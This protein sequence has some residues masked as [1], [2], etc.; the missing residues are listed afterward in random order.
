MERLCPALEPLIGATIEYSNGL[1]FPTTASYTCDTTAGPPPD[2]DATRACQVD[3]TWAGESPT[4][5]PPGNLVL[6]GP[7]RCRDGNSDLNGCDVYNT[8]TPI[9]ADGCRQACLDWE[10][11]VGA[12]VPT[13]GPGRCIL[14]NTNI[15][16]S[17]AGEC[18][19]T[20][21]CGEST[22]RI[23]PTIE[24]TTVDRCWRLT[25]EVDGNVIARADPE[26]TGVECWV[27]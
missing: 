17:G 27:K 11:C 2:G 15:A 22:R 14:W 24:G 23:R 10:F 26:Y 12:D 13:P 3:G 9:T 6:L 5:C 20:V 16:D 4:T 1:V 8:A 7:G 21:D 19:E 18:V 25:A